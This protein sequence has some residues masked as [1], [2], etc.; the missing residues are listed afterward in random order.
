[1]TESARVSSEGAMRTRIHRSRRRALERRFAAAARAG[2]GSQ[3]SDEAAWAETASS[4]GLSGGPPDNV[5]H[6]DGSAGCADALATRSGTLLEIPPVSSLL[7]F[8]AG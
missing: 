2:N 4:V 6:T 5:S 3:K 7:Q 1:M 8:S